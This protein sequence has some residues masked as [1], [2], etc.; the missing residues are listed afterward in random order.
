MTKES[1][2]PKEGEF[3]CTIIGPGYG[4]SIVLH[5]GNGS[6][7][8]VD[9]CLGPSRRAS[10]LEYLES[11]GVNPENKVAM[12]VATHWHDDHVRGIA[13]LIELCSD[14]KFCCSSAF[15]NEEFVTLMKAFEGQLIS[16]VSNG[17]K[18]FHSVF[19]KLSNNGKRPIFALANRVIFQNNACTIT[20]LSPG[21]DV[22]KNFLETV[23]K[24]LP[25]QDKNN[26]RIPNLSP[27][28]LSVAL[29]VKFG[30]CSILL[31]GDL[32]RQGWVTILEE[33]SR[34]IGMASVFKVS[35]HG[36]KNA[37][38][39]EVWKRML[40]DNPFAVVAPW[41]LGGKALPNAREVDWIRN[42]TPNAWIT[43]S[44]GGLFNQVYSKYKNRPVQKTIRESSS[45]IQSVLGDF[46]MVRL[47]RSI[48]S[49]DSW[50][51]EKF[52]D[53]C[54]LSDYSV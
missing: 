35:H 46:S 44:S 28:K 54:H 15:R 19:L 16:D 51:V 40:T 33:S 50:N 14:A 10:A 52:G 6:W 36:S 8:I 13:D 26:R 48:N 12:I 31:G 34:P 27:N 18:Q 45:K 20:A 23:G 1:N 5:V 38:E 42:A 17:L 41:R 22:Y 11:I 39:P 32:E 25:T 7:V 24:L 9:S 43:T 29:W 3:E 37:N 47:R 2:Q 49:V 21:D 53:S 30:T 4:E